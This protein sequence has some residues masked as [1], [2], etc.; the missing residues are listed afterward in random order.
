MKSIIF[1]AILIAIYYQINKRYPDYL[2][3]KNHLYF[4]IFIIV[5]LLLYYLMGY[6]KPFV[7]KVLKNVKE[8][9]QPL[10]DINSMIYKDTQMEGVKNHLA[11]RQGWRCISCQNPIL[12]KDIYS[13]NIEYINPLQFGGTNDINN[14]GIRCTGC[15]AF[16]PY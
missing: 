4:G 15:S 11:M 14:L 10:Y 2:S 8:S 3:N 6:Q 12:Q 1:L 7:Y 13:Y 16:K 5:Y 9:D